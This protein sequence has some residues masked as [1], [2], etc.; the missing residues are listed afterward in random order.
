MDEPS[1]YSDDILPEL[2]NNIGCTL[3]LKEEYKDV[4]KYLIEA[5]NILKEELKKIDN[6]YKTKE[7]EENMDK[8]DKKKLLRFNALKIS[9]DFNLALYYD[10]QAQFDH[11]HFLYK[12]IIGENPYFIEAYIKLSELYKLRGNKKKAESYI[13]LA[14][15][16]H[17]KLVQDERKTQKKEEEKSNEA[18]KQESKDKMEIEKEKENDENKK[19][20]KEGEN[21]PKKTRKNRTKEN[22]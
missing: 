13:K 18:N 5:K 16:K 2:L 10:S 7:S 1:I 12:K 17:Y 21:E 9:V 14:I 4:E 6:K 20:E 8:A 19:E 22:A 15:E 11:S 3:L